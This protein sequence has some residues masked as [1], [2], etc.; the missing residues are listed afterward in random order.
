MTPIAHWKNKYVHIG[1]EDDSV[2][3][4]AGIGITIPGDPRTVIY[5][6]ELKKLD[7]DRLTFKDGTVLKVASSLDAPRVGSRVVVT[8]DAD[9]HVVSSVA[10]A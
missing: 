8:I 9:R 1:L 2:I 3:W 10:K 6:G 4:I 7:D 5:S